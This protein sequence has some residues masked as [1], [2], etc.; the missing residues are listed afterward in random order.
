MAHKEMAEADWPA[1]AEPQPRTAPRPLLVAIPF[2]KN[3]H[4]VA[5]VV[6]SLIRC[7]AD[8]QALGAEVVLYDDSPA[9]APLGTA[10]TDILPRAAAAFPCR[11]ER[12]SANLGFIRTMNKAI[13]EA[14]ARRFDLLLLNS[15]TIVEP[16]ALVEMARVSRL[17]PMIGFVN[18]RSNNASIATLPLTARFGDCVPPRDAYRALAAM[19]PEFTYVPTAIGFCLLI[20]WNIIADF[21]GFDEV[22]GAGYN[23]ENDLV[24]RAGRCGY[25]AVL[26]NHAFVWHQGEQSFGTANFSRD[27]WEPL[28]RAVLLRRYPEYAACTGAHFTAPETTAEQLLAELIPDTE[29]QLDFA[30]DFSSFMPA[31][32]GTFLTGRQLLAVAREV[33]GD[34]FNIYVLC[35]WETFDFFRYAEFGAQWRDPDGPEKYAVIFRIGQPYEWNEVRRLAT[36]GATVGI[37]MLDTISI[38]CPQLTSPRLFNLWQFA[39]DHSDMI[40]ALSRMTL[41]QL[42]NRFHIPER[43]TVATV[44][45]SLDIEDYRIPGADT[46][47]PGNGTVL[48]LGNHYQHKHVAPTANALA[49]AFPDR[50][51]VALGVE[52]PEEERDN[53]ALTTEDLNQSANLTGIAVGGLGENELGAFY[54]GADAVVFP[55]HYEGF[56]MPVLNAL[57]ARRPIFVRDLPVFEELWRGL[58]RNPNIHFY[59]TTDELIERLHDIPKWIATPDAVGNGAAEAMRKI[60]QALDAARERVTYRRA[61]ER[62][63]AVQ[64]VSDSDRPAQAVVRQQPRIG[65]LLRLDGAAFVQ[66]AYLAVLRRGADRDGLTQ[67]I[68]RIEGKGRAE[69]IAILSNLVESEEGRKLGAHIPGLKAYALYYQLL[70]SRNPGSGIFFAVGSEDQH[71]HLASTANALAAAFPDRAIVA[72]GRNASEDNSV[73]EPLTTQHLGWA[74][75]ATGI[76]IC[77]L[78]ESELGLFYADAEAIVFPV[79]YED[80]GLL[81]A[82]AARRPIFARTMSNAGKSWRWMEHNPNIYF[83]DATAELIE[84]LRNIPTWIPAPA[85][86]GAARSMRNIRQATI[87]SLTKQSSDLKEFIAGL[88]WPLR[89]RRVTMQV[90]KEIRQ[91][92]QAVGREVQKNRSD[93]EALGIDISAIG[94]DMAALTR[95]LDGFGRTLE[96]RLLASEQITR[97]NFSYLVDRIAKLQTAEEALAQRSSEPV[98]MAGVVPIGGDA[99]AMGADR[100]EKTR[101]ASSARRND[102]G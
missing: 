94:Q 44:L 88:T 36:K 71:A 45:L 86:S 74:P 98:Q 9:Y 75:N 46:A 72:L 57:A 31:Y 20:R 56:G 82:L 70:Q 5:A 50:S 80:F 25:R 69:K 18:P 28:N 67:C 65:A 89:G 33:L 55:T 41:G 76:S 92:L 4:L 24:M 13:G 15:D 101:L 34:F 49:A 84:R 66:E 7:A 8:L 91:D 3:E 11:M 93:I 48:V 77:D 51:I 17:D 37:Y 78:D 63:R 21:G 62:L 1:S 29:G 22:Y 38:D 95:Q 79:P 97:G 68:K 12:N 43:V 35:S 53:E 2:Y 6:G 102:G 47:Q 19:L 60:R 64:F 27:H 100:Q 58:G 59:Q 16:G 30:F 96:R 73:W 54:A 83:Y 42:Q 14:V 10:L 87:P 52:K 39:L 99:P 85:G 26:A 90:E 61:V 81:G 40:A 23:E 32:N